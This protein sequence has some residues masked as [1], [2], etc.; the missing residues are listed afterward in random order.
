[1][2]L[3]EADVSAGQ[4]IRFSRMLTLPRKGTYLDPLP[5]D[6]LEIGAGQRYSVLITTPDV[7]PAKSSFWFNI[8]TIWR[9]ITTYGAARWTYDTSD[10]APVDKT[11]RP[12]DLNAAVILPNETF[13]WV[14]W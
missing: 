13:G 2:T 7:M 14:G 1:M 8:K 10:Q 4:L 12:A 5:V 9:P 6:N 3:F 11:P